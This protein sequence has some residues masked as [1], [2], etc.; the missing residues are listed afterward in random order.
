[1]DQFEHEPAVWSIVTGVNA[2]AQ[3]VGEKKT[4]QQDQEKF[5]LN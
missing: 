4:L 1:M 3:C 5:F 2:T